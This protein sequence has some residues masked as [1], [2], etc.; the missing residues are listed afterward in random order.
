[1]IC[2]KFILMPPKVPPVQ[3]ITFDKPSSYKVK[4][5]FLTFITRFWRPLLYHLTNPLYVLKTFYCI[6]IVK[7][8]Q[9]ILF[10]IYV[11]NFVK[12]LLANS[13]LF[14]YVMIMIYWRVDNEKANKNV[15][16]K[17]IVIIACL[18]LIIILVLLVYF[19]FFNKDDTSSDSKKVIDYH[20]L[21]LKKD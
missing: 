12:Y 15:E 10:I 7:K 8:F 18:F 16:T 17:R 20:L 6:I 3:N 4:S 19:L 2:F 13:F 21:H 11:K 5:V 14:I 9:D 1:M